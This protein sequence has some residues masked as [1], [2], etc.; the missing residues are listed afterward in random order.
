MA[1][2]AAGG[3]SIDLPAGWDGAIRPVEPTP[4]AATALRGAAVDATAT[5]ALH[6]ARRH[7][8][9]SRRSGATTAPAPSS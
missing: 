8:S 2:L 6:P 9:P 7:A 5:A 4:G 1:A 3:L